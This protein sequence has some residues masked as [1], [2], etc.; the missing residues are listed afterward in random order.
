MKTRVQFLPIFAALLSMVLAL[1]GCEDISVLTAF[2]TAQQGKPNATGQVATPAFNFTSGTY[3]SDLSVTITDSTNGA[4]IYYTTNGET[5]T[6]SSTLYNGAIS[7]PAT[8]QPR[9]SKQSPQSQE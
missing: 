8:A 7:V 1:W 3:S 2:K 4:T 9:R 5:P 6:T